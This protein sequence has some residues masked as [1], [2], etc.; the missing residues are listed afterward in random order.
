LSLGLP[1]FRPHAVD[2]IILSS[3]QGSTLNLALIVGPETQQVNV[4]EESHLLEST[5]ATLGNVVNS[6]QLASLPLLGR[7]LQSLLLTLPGVAPIQN[8]RLNYSPNGVGINASIRGHRPR[9]NA[10][11]LDG[12]PNVEILFGAVPM[13]PPP[14]AIAEMKVQSGMDSGTHGFAAGANIDVVTKAGTNDYHGDVWEYL[15]NGKMKAHGLIER[16]G[17]RYAYRLTDKGTK[18]ALLFVLFHNQL[19][20]PLAN[21]LFHHQ[22]E[23]QRRP[24][25][26]LEMAYHKADPSICNI[27][28]LLEAA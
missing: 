21:S 28:E 7:S 1:V 8:V 20:G 4:T 10:Y 22:P 11:M 18:V 24:K 26:K 12:V 19:C 6:Q 15:Q 27:I 14:E 25:S 9:N 3:G 23:S 5:T 2:N 16:D 17:K 13:F